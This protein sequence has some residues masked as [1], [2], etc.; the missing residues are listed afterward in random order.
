MFVAPT[1]RLVVI[2]FNFYGHQ[3]RMFLLNYHSKAVQVIHSNHLYG[4]MFTIKNIV[5]MSSFP[6]EDID[7]C[8]SFEGG[9]CVEQ[10]KIFLLKEN[11]ISNSSL[12]L[13]QELEDPNLRHFIESKSNHVMALP[14]QTSQS[15]LRHYKHFS[16]KSFLNAY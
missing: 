10:I 9:V 7:S 4:S 6:Y 5:Y 14:F 15:R 2:N 8:H 3:P 16:Y 12:S 1:Y 11:G 13:I